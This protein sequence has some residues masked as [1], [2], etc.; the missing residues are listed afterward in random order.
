MVYRCT[1]RFILLGFRVG[2][3][4]RQRGRTQANVTAQKLVAR[5]EAGTTEGQRL[6]EPDPS[7]N[8][9]RKIALYR[10]DLSMSVCMRSLYSSD[11]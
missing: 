6:E 10:R 8:H 4:T 7:K 9:R 11:Q 1:V 3:G 2:H 5:S